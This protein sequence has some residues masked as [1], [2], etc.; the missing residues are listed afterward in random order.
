MS[1]FFEVTQNLYETMRGYFPEMV[2][3]T[4]SVFD[5]DLGFFLVW[6][7]PPRNSTLLYQKS[8]IIAIFRW[9]HPMEE[10]VVIVIR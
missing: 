3:F 8:K 7:N 5:P 9:F 4:K 6:F 10:E 2:M 1:H